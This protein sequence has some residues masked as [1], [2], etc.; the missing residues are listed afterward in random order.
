MIGYHF[1]KADMRTGEGHEPP[2]EIGEA[3][4]IEP[5]RIMLCVEGYHFCRTLWDALQYAPGPMACKVEVPNDAIYIEDKGVAVSRKLIA[6]VNVEK[7][8]R[9]FACDCA[10]RVLHI[11]ERDYPEDKRPRIAI[12]TS[13]RFVQG[14]ATLPPTASAKYAA[15]DAAWAAARNAAKDAAWAAARNAAWAAAR[16]AAW[17]AAKDAER[18]WQLRHFNEMMQG[19]FG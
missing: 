9:L 6:A 5:S 2:W 12:E 11:Y 13:R 17:N 18:Q 7:E 3:R 15:R 1:L 10:E 8:L 16:A 4:T 14:L 19:I